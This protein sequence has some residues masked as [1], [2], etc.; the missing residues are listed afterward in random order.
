LNE[1]VIQE[2]I[3]QKLRWCPSFGNPNRNYTQPILLEENTDLKESESVTFVSF[4]ELGY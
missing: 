4:P 2:V 3:F 1:K